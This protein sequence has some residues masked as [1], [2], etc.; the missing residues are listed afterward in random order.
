[1]ISKVATS[2]YL[3]FDDHRDGALFDRRLGE[4]PPHP[5]GAVRYHLG[6]S[7]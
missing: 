6:V 4:D 3:P 5:P 2:R 7:F 1:L